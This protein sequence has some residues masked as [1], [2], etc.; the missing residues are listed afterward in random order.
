[1]S[2]SEFLIIFAIGVGVATYLSGRKLKDYR[3]DPLIAERMFR[4]QGHL[5]FIYFAIF[6]GNPAL[7]D[8]ISML[9]ITITTPEEMPVIQL[10]IMDIGLILVSFCTD[11]FQRR[12]LLGQ[13]WRLH[14]A[15]IVTSRFVLAMS[16]FWITLILAPSLVSSIPGNCN[17]L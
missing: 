16:G 1:M 2:Y 11:H 4:H 10:V 5:G 8:L 14:E 3:D 17:Y 12:T 6:I 9:G 13:S 15:M 7:A